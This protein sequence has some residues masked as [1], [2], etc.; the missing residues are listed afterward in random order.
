MTVL[1][2][3]LGWTLVHFLWQGALLG[4]ATAAALRLCRRRSAECRY[5]VACIGLA[6]MVLAPAVTARALWRTAAA[7]AP[8]AD[9]AARPSGSARQPPAS[10]AAAEHAAGPALPASSPG[11]E[12]LPRWM[13]VIVVAW[14]LGATLLLARFTGG[15]WRIRRLLRRSRRA[16]A[17]R[18]QGRA[19]LLASRLGIGARVPVMEV[20]AVGA[21]AVIGTWRPMILLPISALTNLT[22]DQIDAILAHELAHIRRHDYLVNLLQMLVEA[23]LFYH[24][25]IWWVSSRIREAREYC[26]DDVAVGLC[27]EP[28][29]YAEA[30]TELATWRA[31]STATAVGASDGS[32]LARVRRLLDTPS[33]ERSAPS[34]GV[35]VGVA[36]GMLVVAG[37]AAHSSASLL[38][39]GPAAGTARPISGRS[40]HQLSPV[41]GQERP[42]AE[43]RVETTDHFEIHFHRDLDLHAE[44]AALEAERAYATVSTDLRHMLAFRI[45]LV[46]FRSADE[47][48][49]YA[50]SGG[51][52]AA[53]APQSGPSR[54][55]ILF[56][57]DQPVPQW[58]GLLTHEVTHV[59]T[60]DIIPASS[61][62]GWVLEGLAEYERGIWDP[63]PLSMLRDAVRTGT[64]PRLTELPGPAGR[65][66]SALSLA[67]AHAAFD[68]IESRW[69]K[70]GIRQ[71][72]LAIRQSAQGGP[73][74]YE[75]ALDLDAQGFE[76]ALSRHLAERFGGQIARAASATTSPAPAVRLQGHVA[77]IDASPAAGLACVDL[78]VGFGGPSARR[79]AV[80][81]QDSHSD[82]LRALKPGDEIIVTGRQ[83]ER[84]GT[85]R[86]LLESLVRPRDGLRW[87]ASSR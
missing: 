76:A 27:R 28:A 81:C 86:L 16:P 71:F 54:N 32:L 78:I 75:A 5:A 19:Q 45:P 25:A 51:R 42:P 56:A 57:V 82:L 30:L 79:W 21:P 2:S 20:E 70:P 3:V 38:P 8:A 53:G 24:P 31:G 83:A 29:L 23:V 40:F 15:C 63:A 60:F 33:P 44:R 73:N 7:V 12:V 1:T 55:R 48:E 66:E 52:A 6:V 62:P 10:P 35:L 26:C 84:W 50:S 59:F 39:V 41:Q 9:A 46:L 11:T 64:L 77:G 17:S 85:S 13:S 14:G 34:I 49:A 65:G 69:G 67:Y 61:A 58:S 18:W 36:A 47:L 74:P 37:A 22:P 80:E 68:F 87:P 72:L 4:L 43:W